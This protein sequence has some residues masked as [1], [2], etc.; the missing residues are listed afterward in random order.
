MSGPGVGDVGSLPAGASSIVLVQAD[1][2]EISDIT[3]D[4]DNTAITSGAVVGGA[5][6][7]A[8]NG[9]IT[10]H[11]SVL[12]FTG[13]NVHDVT[14]QNVYLRG[15]QA[16]TTFGSFT[17]ADNTVTNVQGDPES[18]GI[19]NIQGGSGTISGNVVD[20]ATTGIST[21]FSLGTTITGN[22]VRNSVVGIASNN[23][24]GTGS[25]TR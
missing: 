3:F 13:L 23:N 4:G 21:N 14:V 25:T 16:S 12:D 15:I 11:N 10:D 1:D 7:D 22:T 17:F 18:V 20:G 24:D 6:I 19:A 8:R 5:D 2:V 9:I